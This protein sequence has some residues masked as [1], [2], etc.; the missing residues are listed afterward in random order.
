MLLDDIHERPHDVPDMDMKSGKMKGMKRV[1]DIF[2]SEIVLNI[3]D[4]ARFKTL[5]EIK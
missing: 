1:R 2:Q 5:T 4:A 3:E